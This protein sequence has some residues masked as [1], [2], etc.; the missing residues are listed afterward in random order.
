MAEIYPTDKKLTSI[1]YNLFVE[2]KVKRREKV[3][4]VKNAES[5][6]TIRRFIVKAAAAGLTEKSSVPAAEST[7]TKAV[8]SAFIAAPE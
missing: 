6:T 2:I 1:Y 8:R 7:T 5:K 3:W 4:S